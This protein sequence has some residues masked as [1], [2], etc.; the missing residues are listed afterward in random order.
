MGRRCPE[1]ADEGAGCRYPDRQSTP[2]PQPSPHGESGRPAP[3]GRLDEGESQSANQLWLEIGFGGGEHLLWQAEHNP[4]V[5]IIGCEPFEDGVVKVLTVLDQT[6]LSNIRL[7]MGD[8]RDVLRWLPPA[9]IDRAFIL[10]PD[11]WPKR[12]HQKRRL[13]NR[14][15]LDLLARVMKS[16]A[17]LRFGTDIGD[18]ARSALLAF[19]AEPRFE[20]TAQAAADWRVRP[21]DWP[22]TRYEAKADRE[23]RRR[24]YFRFVR[25]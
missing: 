10:F 2:S 13:V 17:E 16:G 20:W 19:K 11:P 15:T 21:D 1:G 3:C 18:Y 24:Y 8:A 4:Q 14:A 25:R 5:T 22:Q 6:K 23:G 9:S 12:K 7:H